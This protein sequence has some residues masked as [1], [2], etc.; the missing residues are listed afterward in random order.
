MQRGEAPVHRT[1]E[2]IK[3]TENT[4]MAR[5]GKK[6]T[7]RKWRWEMILITTSMMFMRIISDYIYTSRFL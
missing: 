6:E 7:K 2:S 3:I 1:K 4:K 5:K